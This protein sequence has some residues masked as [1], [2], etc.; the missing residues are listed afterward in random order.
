[1]YFYVHLAVLDDFILTVMAY[2]HFVAICHPVIMSPLL[3]GLLVL[4]FWVISA[5]H[6]LLESSMVPQLS[7]CRDLDIPTSFVKSNR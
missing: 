5:L 3:C 6:S 4:V 7:F 1:M 2:D